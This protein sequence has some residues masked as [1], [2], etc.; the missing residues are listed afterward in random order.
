[1]NSSL[2]GFTPGDAFALAL[3][4]LVNGDDREVIKGEIVFK[5]TTEETIEDEH[6]SDLL[7][8]SAWK[9]LVVGE[10]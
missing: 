1:M 6:M 5:T 4:K 3:H 7:A 10:T 8:A 9:K 2:G